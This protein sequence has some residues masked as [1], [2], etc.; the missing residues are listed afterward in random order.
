M[1]AEREGMI[2]EREGEDSRKRWDDSINK[3]NDCRKLMVESVKS[4]KCPHVI[5][6]SWKSEQ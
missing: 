1:K 5:T 6:G 2:A 3:R 4:I